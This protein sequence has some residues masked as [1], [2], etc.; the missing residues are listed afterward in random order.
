MGEI[1]STEPTIE[2]IDQD[3]A[4]LE[5]FDRVHGSS[6]ADFLRKAS[7]GGA[8]VFMALAAP[9][10]HARAA[11]SETQILNF[12]LTFEYMQAG[13]YTEALQVGTIDKMSPE[14]AR[15]AKVFGEHE[16]AHVKLLESV[17]GD[18][19][20]RKPVFNFRGV[21]ENESQFAKTVVALEDLTTAL[22]AGQIPRFT[23]PALVS[24]LFSL[25]TV[26]ARHAAWVRHRRGFLPVASAFDEPQNLKRVADVVDATNF[27][28]RRALTRATAAPRFTG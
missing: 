19:K 5:A 12:D 8:A 4:F 26:E 10:R 2:D 14:D 23:T 25:L 17:L 9:P 24:A 15:W 11:K 7:F 13:F 18:A 16:T 28:S 6:R 20:V 1:M 21:T 3:G 27:V 22:L